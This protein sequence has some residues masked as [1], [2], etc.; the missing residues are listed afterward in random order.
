LGGRERERKGG[1]EGK[2]EEKGGREIQPECP[3]H[4]YLFFA[5]WGL[6]TS[7]DLPQHN[8]Y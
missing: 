4:S 7:Y 3:G 6:E 8:Y 5:T 1:R 2:K